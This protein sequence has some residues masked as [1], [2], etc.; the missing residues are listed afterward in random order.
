MA[1]NGRISHKHR[2]H[3]NQQFLVMEKRTRMKRNVIFEEIIEFN[4]TDSPYHILKNIT[5][6][7]E[8]I[9]KIHAGTDIIFTQNTGIIVYGTLHL[10]GQQDNPITLK[11]SSHAPWLGIILNQGGIIHANYC[12]LKNAAIGLNVSSSNIAIRNMQIIRP[13]STGILITTVYNGTFD[14]GESIILQSRGNGIRILKRQ[15]IQDV[16]LLRNALIMDCAESGIDFMDPAGKIMLQNIVLENSGS[17]GILV[18]QRE[19]NELDSI[20]LSNLTIRK[21]ERGSGG[22]LL[23]LKSYNLLYLNTS[24]FISNILP[25][26]IIFSKCSLNG[27]EEKMRKM[28]IEKNGFLKNENLVMRITL[29]GCENAKIERNIFIGN[30][31]IERKGVL[32]IY[33][34]PQVN[35]KFGQAI[36]VAQNIFLENKGEWSLFA[37]ATNMNQFN[38]TIHN[39][40]F[41]GNQNYHNSLIVNTP[42]FQVNDNKFEQT[43]ADIKHAYKEALNAMENN[44]RDNNLLNAEENAFELSGQSFSSSNNIISLTRINSINRKRAAK[45]CLAVSNCSHN[46]Q[47]IGLNVCHCNVGYVGPDCSQISCLALKNCS[48]NG[49]CIAP[50]IC[51]CFDGWQQQDCSK[52]T[53]H[54]VNNCSGHGTCVSLN[55]CDCEP[56]FEGADCSKQMRNCSNT[57]CNNHGL[58]INNECVCETGWTGSFCSKALCDQLNNCSG[59]GTCVRPQLCECLHGFTGDDCSVCEGPTCD[60][61]NAEC[62]HGRCNSNTRTCICRGGWTGPNCDICASEKCDVMS[63]VLYVL[64]TAAGIHQKDENI[65][66]YGNDLPF[67]SSKRYTCLYGSTAA[68]G[69]YISSSLVRCTI[70]SSALPGRYL[71]NIIPYGSDK[72]VPFLDKRLIHF[73][74]Y[75]ECNQAKCKGYCLGAVCVC[76]ADRDGAFCEQAKILPKLNREI[77]SNEKLIQAVE[78]EP[79]TVKMP[80]QHENTIFNVETDANGMII[81]PNGMVFW[82]QPIGRIQPYT[83]NVTATSLTGGSMISWNL[84]VKPIYTPV[85]TKVENVDDTNMKVIKGTVNHN[86]KLMGKVPIRML[87][88]QNDKLIENATAISTADGHFKFIHYPF[89]ETISTSV[90]VVHPGA[91]KPDAVTSS[92]N[93]TWTTPT[94]DIEYTPKIKMHPDEQIDEDYQL[95]NKGR[96]VLLNC[97]LELIA[98]RDKIQITKYEKI[99]KGIAVGESK[100]MKVTFAAGSTLDNTTLILQFKCVDTSKKLVRQQIE[101]ERERSMFVSYPSEMLVSIPSQIP[102][103][104]ITVDIVNKEGYQFVSEP[105]I[106]I[107]PDYGS[108]FLISTKPSLQNITEFNNPESTLTLFLSYR[109]MLSAETMNWTTTG[110]LILF[111]GNKELFTVEYRS[112]ATSNLFDFQ[113][114]VMD[115]LSALDPTH[116]VDDAEIILR[117]EA[118]GYDYKR[119]TKPDAPV[120][121]FSII[122]GTY[123]LTVKSPTH[124]TVITIIQPSFINSSLA[125]FAPIN[126]PYSP[127][128]E[129]GKLLL[130]EID[131]QRK[132]SFPKL[133]FTPS[134]IMIPVN[135]TK[136]M[137]LLIS[138]DLDGPTDNVAILPS[139]EIHQQP[140]PFIFA[141]ADLRNGLGLGDGYHMKYKLSRVSNHTGNAIA[142]T[143]FALQIPYIYMV[144]NSISNYIRNVVILAD[145]RNKPNDN[146]QL[147]EVGLQTAPKHASIWT[148]TTIYCNCAMRGKERCRVQYVSATPC[149]T[150]W[151]YIPDDTVS[152]Q[153]TALFIVMIA[154]CRAAGV[155]FDKIKQFL[156]CASLLNNYCPISQQQRSFSKNKSSWESQQ[157]TQFFDQLA[158]VNE[159]AGDILQK[160]FPIMKILKSQTVDIVALYEAF[161][162]RLN[163]LL[164]FKHFEEI[165]NKQWFNKFFESIS[166]SSDNG[167]AIT[168]TEFEKLK[169]EKGGAILAHR[170]N[171]TVIEWSKISSLPSKANISGM[172]FTDA[173]ELIISSDRLKTLTKQ[174]GADNPFALLHDYMGKLLSWRSENMS[175]SQ[176]ILKFE[177][178]YEDI[179]AY[180]YTLITPEKPYENSEFHIRLKVINKKEKSLESVKVTL[181][182]I[183]SH[184]SDSDAVPMQ[185]RIGTVM[186]NGISSIDRTSNLPPNASFVASWNLKPVK[187]TRLIHETEYQPIVILKFTQNGHRSVQRITTQTVIFQPRPS[188]KIYYFISNVTHSKI[189]QNTNASQSAFNVMIAFINTG[190]SNLTN[191]KVEEVRISVLSK[192]IAKNFIPYQINGI[193]SDSGSGVEQ[194]NLS[195][196]HFTIA[197]IESG[198]TVNAMYNITTDFGQAKF[199][200]NSL[201]KGI[202]RDFKMTTSINGE[203][204]K[205]EDTQTFTI[206]QFI[207]PTKFLVSLQTNSASLFYYDMQKAAMRT[208]APLIFVNVNEKNGASDGKSF[209]Q[210]IITFRLNESQRQPTSF[211]GRIPFPID[212]ENDFEV[213][214]VNQISKN[215]ALK[216]VDPRNIWSSNHDQKFVHFI[217]DNLSEAP[218]FIEYEIIYGN[219]ELF[220]RPRFEFPVYNVPLVTENW[221]HVGDEIARIMAISASQSTIRYELYS[222]S[223]EMN[224]YFGINPETGV[225]SLKKE[226]K[227]AEIENSY[228]ATVQAVDEYGRSETAVVTIGFDGFI[229]ECHKIIN[230]NG[231]QPLIY[232]PS[233]FHFVKST[234]EMN[235]INGNAKHTSELPKLYRLS[236]ITTSLLSSTLLTTRA[237]TAEA[238]TSEIDGYRITPLVTR[239]HEY[240]KLIATQSIFDSNGIFNLTSDSSNTFQLSST[241]ALDSR[242][243]SESG[244]SVVFGT[245]SDAA[246]DATENDLN[247]PFFPNEFGSSSTESVNFFTGKSYKEHTIRST[248]E[249]MLASHQKVQ[250]IFDRTSEGR[251]T[252]SDSFSSRIENG[253]SS[254]E[255]WYNTDQ[256]ND[257]PTVTITDPYR[258]FN[259]MGQ[260][261]LSSESRISTV[262]F[263]LIN[264]AATNDSSK[265]IK[266]SN[267][268]LTTENNASNESSTEVPEFYSLFPTKA[269][270]KKNLFSAT[271]LLHTTV[272]PNHQTVRR[273]ESICNISATNTTYFNSPNSHVEAIL[274][275]SETNRESIITGNTTIRNNDSV[276]YQ[277]QVTS[278]HKSTYYNI[279]SPN[280]QV[281]EF[282][283]QNNT[284]MWNIQPATKI[285]VTLSSGELLVNSEDNENISK[286]ACR[287]KDTQPIWG[288]IC[289]LS[290]TLR[291]IE[292]PKT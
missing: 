237:K 201:V 205:L 83:V 137:N 262:S 40:H 62:I 141:T 156:A 117:N 285:P 271:V 96:E 13:I 172:K 60:L 125:I 110:D 253:R 194:R 66:V 179:C 43:D 19:K 164:P 44:W 149:G 114:T 266:Y 226:I 104:I 30:N 244:L 209:R 37:S 17:F 195:D 161:F 87:V 63:V 232:I 190:Y 154:E 118:L 64:P 153:T 231:L 240:T 78:G 146:V 111:D 148:K 28:L 270:I 198:K 26:V 109:S 126:S 39:N 215:N 234:T 69:F 225:I 18:A 171:A 134:I 222:N 278:F 88:Y 219:T 267:K 147:C 130:E 174:Y 291:S 92:N 138:S 115:E 246:A 213:L 36:D 23:N 127:I 4:A 191:V 55:E 59:S 6:N 14:M 256:R 233:Q 12:I 7:S 158:M 53:C 49:Y 260:S 265:I 192:D 102:P 16:L 206:Q 157:R 259:T 1:V 132:I 251:I 249:D 103:K 163:N 136:E 288:L 97:Q 188:L 177:N 82:S 121:F 292:K 173:R 61:C 282:S 273:T 145:N 279:I 21:Q 67:V 41:N 263:T 184:A 196:L 73:T 107:R 248:K 25:S 227:P 38:G 65:L 268:N 257:I 212:L 166:E 193:I 94:F 238:E 77:L 84:M 10:L 22:I 243:D 124:V 101:V 236:Y 159:H 71:F 235:V 162:E 187:N 228:C 155:N 261:D 51:K 220:L 151:K 286:M 123:Q 264:V 45:D 133:H 272:A 89:D 47:C 68:D 239:K 29:E 224:D 85:I 252:S 277:S 139:V 58:C 8:Q 86:A 34:S 70:P 5:I 216:L 46:G 20:V 176:Q 170:W 245:S 258:I 116:I 9:L 11:S 211:Y 284:E 152:L 54:L 72:A 276:N 144:P 202:I 221:P 75:N 275:S 131:K 2:K 150:T 142:C 181:E 140:L 135:G 208:I 203:L 290:K 27:N 269:P 120:V 42:H 287:L 217:D 180:A 3:H 281:T 56:M 143:V 168:E 183:Q 186:L 57:S 204:I 178:D 160:Y 106:F 113:I 283:G 32:A 80:I 165:K 15:H 31:E 100:S 199:T 35:V 128:V 189:I 169:G 81:Y 48:Q 241:V 200:F 105:R 210:Q 280:L 223:S 122:E 175:N 74:L 98:P 93:V 95:T 254:D 33:V 79:Y 119:H 129:D 207:S 50:N 99:I 289:D 91:A 247:G 167:L 242:A 274:P 24:N 76:P 197:N 185:F 230:F 182:M 214:R 255:Q 250:G 229:R 218:E 52:P 112:Y 108:L 90:V